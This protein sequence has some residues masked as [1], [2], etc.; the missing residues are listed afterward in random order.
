MKTLREIITE[1]PFAHGMKPEHLEV[2]V[3]CAT[4]VQLKTDQLLFHEG[5]PANQFYLVESGR[6]AIEA[7]E[8]A[9]GSALVQVIEAGDVVGWS[10]LFPPFSWHFQARALEPTRAIMLNGAHLLV[11]AERN[12][13]FG[14]DLMKRVSKTVIHR[15]QAARKRIL[16]HGVETTIDG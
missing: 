13:A 16:G 7:H 6:V 10:W 11:T 5:E 8:P 4:E 14:Y 2:L 1:H 15:L 3:E 9:D 12:P